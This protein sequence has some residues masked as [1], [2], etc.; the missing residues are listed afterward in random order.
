MSI[1]YSI[2]SSAY[3]EEENISVL[4]EKFNTF[5]KEHDFKYELIIIDD[6]STDNTYKKAIELSKDNEFIII[7]KHKK[8][9]GKTAGIKTGIRIARGEI[10]AIYD[11]DMQYSL[12]ELPK[13]I[14]RIEEDNFDIC[15]GWK[16]GNYKKAFVSNVYNFLSRKIFRL[17]I[18][19]QNGL[20]VMRK[21]IIENIHLRKDWHRYIVSLAIDKGYSVTE[22]KVTLHPRKYGKSKYD[23]P[24]RIFIGVFDM[25]TVKFLISFI[26]KPMIFFGGS[27]TL[28]IILGFIVGLIALIMR[29]FFNNGFRPLLY[30][31]MLLILA[32]LILFTMGFLAEIIAIIYEDFEEYKKKK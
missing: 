16:Q 30:L 5:N 24:F 1:K 11:T 18:H 32:G 28:S 20:K 22:E 6:G 19:D 27:G 12:E 23:N 15:T 29:V 14:K 21:E 31:V 8:N 10:I 9:F 25:M 7:E 17:P 13:L 2:I 26:K 4:F 3:N